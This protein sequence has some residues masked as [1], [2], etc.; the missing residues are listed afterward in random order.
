MPPVNRYGP[1][2]LTTPFPHLQ[3][4]A[5]LQQQQNQ[6]MHAAHA[7]SANSILPPPS[8]GGHPGFGTGSSTSTM[9]PFGLSGPTIA[10]GVVGF[11][12]AGGVDGGATGLASH[13]AQMGFV[14]GAQIQ[15]Q[16]TLQQSHDSRMVIEGKANSVKTR[17]RDVWKHNLA[18]EMA[19][20]RRLVEKYP[21]I[22]MVQ[23]LFNI[24]FDEG[25][26]PSPA[27]YYSAS[28]LGHRI[29]WHCCTTHWVFYNEGRLSLSNTSV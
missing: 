12:S 1:S 14:R 4:Q 11:G 27:D 26:D 25:L 15:Q 8:L 23:L 7:Q 17:I 22:S 29:P 10:N 2:G 24:F 20:L 16:H 3:Q 9:S 6:Q 28:P 13:A 18:Q 19:I 5:H 21:Y